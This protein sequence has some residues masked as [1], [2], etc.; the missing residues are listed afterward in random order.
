MKGSFLATCVIVG[1]NL[2]INMLYNPANKK[3]ILLFSRLSTFSFAVEQQH[4]EKR[5]YQLL[6]PIIYGI[7]SLQSCSIYSS[8]WFLSTPYS[9]VFHSNDGGQH[10]MDGRKPEY[11]LSSNQTIER[12][13]CSEGDLIYIEASNC[14]AGQLDR[15][16]HFERWPSFSRTTCMDILLNAGQML[17]LRC[18][19][20][21][22]TDIWTG[23]HSYLTGH[24]FGEREFTIYQCGEITY[25]SEMVPL[26]NILFHL[27]LS[28]H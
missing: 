7:L 12:Q 11:F 4:N 24:L 25:P 20:V 5:S 2:F 15:Q 13:N 6:N 3:D 22:S 17:A 16:W 28:E 21:I 1:W 9:K 23:Q 10:I 26:G 14:A 19:S 8:I 27:I 18:H